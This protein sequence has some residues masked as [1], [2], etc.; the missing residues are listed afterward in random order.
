[1]GKVRF[2][3]F[4]LLIA[5]GTTTAIFNSCGKDDD[6]K[7]PDIQD[8]I[9]G[10]IING[11]RWATRNVAAPGTFAANPEASGMFYQWNRNIGWSA[12][13]PMVNS[14]GGT[15]WDSSVPIGTTWE[16]SN[17][18]SPIGWRV[19]TREELQ[20]L[21]ETAKVSN[22]WTNLNGVNGRKFTDKISGNSMFLP[23]AGYRE[24]FG[25]TLGNVG[26]GGYYWS[27][28]QCGSGAYG[29]GFYSGNGSWYDGY[30]RNNGISVRPVAE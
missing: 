7:T 1:M 2:F 18:P 25:G 11:V 14:N 9:N 4:L 15:T 30:F 20:R 6:G 28:T 10:V 17:D 21:L 22:E 29:M 23:A 8:D 12:T 24:D 3:S 5:L 13:N 27:S 16:K 19:P 26:S